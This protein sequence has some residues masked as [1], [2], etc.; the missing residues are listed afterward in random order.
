[1]DKPISPVD[2][3]LSA[4]EVHEVLNKSFY[5]GAPAALPSRKPAKQATPPKAD[6]Y[7]IICIS[8]YKDD[9]KRL[10]AK[11]GSLKK[12]GH[13]KMSRSAL[14][15]YALDHVDTAKLPKSY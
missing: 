1:M 15:R 11:V 13:R 7:E 3:V 9:L 14:I 8:L 4:Q 10:D 6:H 5:K 2:D 12:Q